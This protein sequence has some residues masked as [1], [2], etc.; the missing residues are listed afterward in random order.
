MSLVELGPRLHSD[1]P[2]PM[3]TG[4]NVIDRSPPK[5]VRGRRT[6][7]RHNDG[8]VWIRE[9]GKKVENGER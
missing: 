8:P 4:H 3:A 2:F 5:C 7:R 1:C 9:L 6:K